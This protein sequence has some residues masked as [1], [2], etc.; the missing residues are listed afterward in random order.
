MNESKSTDEVT[1]SHKVAG[2]STLCE[3]SVRST[4]GTCLQ[5]VCLP[6]FRRHEFDAGFKR[7]LERSCRANLTLTT[8]QGAYCF[9]EKRL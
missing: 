4:A 1:K 9:E 8:D 3:E 7:E 2:K 5:A 6:L